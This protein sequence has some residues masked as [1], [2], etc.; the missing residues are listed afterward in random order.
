[1]A[2]GLKLG[3]SGYHVYNIAQ[4]TAIA[5]FA[6]SIGEF[7][8]GQLA[9][10]M[11]NLGMSAAVLPEMMHMFGVGADLESAYLRTGGNPISQQLADI[12]E[13]AG[14]RVGGRQSAYRVDARDNLVRAFR[15]GKL[16]NEFKA[17]IKGID[18]GKEH[19]LIARGLATGPR[20]ALVMA[21]YAGRALDTLNAPLFDKLIPK[22]KQGAWASEMEDFLRQ[23][24]T[25]DER[26]MVTH[27][28][29]TM[30]SIDDRFGEMNQDNLFWN[31]YAKQLANLFTVSIGWEY[32]TLRA[33]GHAG[34]D[35]GTGHWNS[36]RARWLPAFL[37]MSAYQNSAYQYAKTSTFPQ[38]LTQTLLAPATGGKLPGRNSGSPEGAVLPGYQKEEIRAIT[39]AMKV[40]DFIGG[41]QAIGGY[42]ASKINPFFQ[43]LAH[44][45]T[46]NDWDGD[47]VRLKLNAARGA[48]PAW[49]QYLGSIAGSMTSPVLASNLQKRKGTEIGYGERAMGIRPAGQ[50]LSDPERYR[51]NQ[52][53]F[54]A[55]DLI[56]ERRKQMR[57][58]AT[59]VPLGE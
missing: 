26:A 16:G 46:D 28:R 37:A 56:K 25:A 58:N 55:V 8:H 21:D 31:R 42:A 15:Q 29:Q 11:G 20:A 1:M 53:H 35:I 13:K 50:N 4:E 47:S 9:T 18:I 6:R 34:L 10:A 44:I 33:F 43:G 5:G 45:A 19:S 59:L 48:P 14:G 27:G 12:F 39:E 51:Q 22:I 49:W 23:N 54:R 41:I 32:G 17:D 2:T 3:L 57:Y 52:A 30:D 36:T 24:P 38:N 7:S 40:P